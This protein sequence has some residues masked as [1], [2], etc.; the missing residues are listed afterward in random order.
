M[1]K[2]HSVT[3]SIISES[4]GV[5]NQEILLK[6]YA[7]TPEELVI[8]NFAIADVVINALQDGMK[9]LAGAVSTKK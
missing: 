7:S 6:E 5:L 3:V 1:S 4:N 2:P 8:K 9:V